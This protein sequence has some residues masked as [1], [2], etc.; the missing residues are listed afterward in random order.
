MKAKLAVLAAYLHAHRA[1]QS[2]ASWRGD[3]KKLAVRQAEIDL[4]VYDIHLEI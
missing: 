4:Y 2:V 1:R 3:N